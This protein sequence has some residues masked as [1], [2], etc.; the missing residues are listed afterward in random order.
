[1]SRAPQ[2]AEN[3]VL[4]RAHGS[5]ALFPYGCA[6]TFCSLLCDRPSG[7]ARMPRTFP[8]KTRRACLTFPAIRLSLLPISTRA[9][10]LVTPFFLQ[11]SHGL[12][13]CTALGPLSRVHTHVSAPGSRTPSATLCKIFQAWGLFI[14]GA[15]QVD[16]ALEPF[17]YDLVNLGRELLAQLATPVSLNFSNVIKAAKIDPDEAKEVPRPLLA[18]GEVAALLTFVGTGVFCSL[19]S[20]PP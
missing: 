1:M 19:C 11:P 14:E 18:S 4:C 13:C 10:C 7:A 9:L 20:C 16:P 12:Y 8:Y 6:L 3:D 15:P 5:V 2:G 17:R